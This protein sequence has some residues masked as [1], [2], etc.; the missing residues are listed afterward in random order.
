MSVRSGRGDKGYTDLAFKDRIRKD[1][2]DIRAIGDLDELISYLGLVKVKIR[3]R[4]YKEILE[5][6]Q[7][8]LST[9]ATEIAIGKQKKQYLGDLLEK[10]EADWIEK[11]IYELES[12]V[13]IESCFYVPGKS[14]V[15]ALSDIARAVARRAERSVVAL[16]LKDKIKNNN[17]LLFLNCV[18]DILFII[19]RQQERGKRKK[20]KSSTRNRGNNE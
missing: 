10:K 20:Q 19:A 9:A 5:R 1:S 12:K 15:S 13:H 2:P 17:M 16:F 6:I 3:S 8:I 14:E 11:V 7:N 4:K 18:S